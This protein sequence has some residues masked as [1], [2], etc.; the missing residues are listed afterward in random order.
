MSVVLWLDYGFSLDDTNVRRLSTATETLV[1]QFAAATAAGQHPHPL[2]VAATQGLHD[3][4][5]CAAAAT[6]ANA[7]APDAAAAHGA[8]TDTVK[9]C[10][11]V[12]KEISAVAPAQSREEV[13]AFIEIAHNEGDTALA[14]RSAQAAGLLAGCCLSLLPDSFMLSC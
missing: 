2:V 10:G 11:D 1:M 12:D 7:A 8:V 4:L 14:A 3:I 9:N 6:A 13:N 5:Y